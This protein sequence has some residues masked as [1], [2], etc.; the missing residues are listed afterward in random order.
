LDAVRR[1][2][3][4]VPFDLA[5]APLLRAALV[6]TGT[7]CGVLL[8][9]AHHIACDGWTVGLIGHEL[10]ALLDGRDLDSPCSYGDFAG[11]QRQLIGS[12]E[13]SDSMS[14]W[15][16]ELDPLPAPL[17]LHESGTPD[18]D[19]A[20]ERREI[21]VDL[22]AALHDVASERGSTLFSVVLAAFAATVHGLTDSRRFI[23][24]VPFENRAL[25]TFERT[26]GC[27]VN[28]LPLVAEVHSGESFEALHRRCERRALA[29]H[30]H[31]MVPHELLVRRL[32]TVAGTRDALLEA[33]LAYQPPREAAFADSLPGSSSPESTGSARFDL[34][35]DVQE[36]RDMLLVTVDG[37]ANAFGAR[38]TGVLADA[39]M[40]VMQ[41][42]GDGG[43]RCTLDELLSF[44]PTPRAGS[45]LQR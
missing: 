41:R 3:V 18:S 6:L 34:L 28:V 17:E 40:T 36:M 37:A 1:Q 23:V 7:D 4:R 11:W 31:Q 44:V 30:E 12:P 29:A 24:G 8:V 19:G 10:R 2:R 14:Y 33:V 21:S 43:A 26:A 15:L 13:F 32:R 5:V 45:P 25:P 35:V 20:L 38:S 39:L 27:F 9:E 42:I 22:T 16:E